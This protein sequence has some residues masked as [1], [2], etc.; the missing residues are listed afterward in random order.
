MSVDKA[1]EL[2]LGR[3]VA[4]AVPGSGTMPHWTREGVTNSWLGDHFRLLH[5]LKW[6]HRRSSG[7]QRDTWIS[8]GKSW[9]SHRT[10]RESGPRDEFVNFVNARDFDRLI[11]PYL[12]YA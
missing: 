4:L 9:K 8:S 1:Q 6:E 7:R 5:E 3:D 12:R 2:F 11:V 10:R